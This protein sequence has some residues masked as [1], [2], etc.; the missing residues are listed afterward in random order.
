MSEHSAPPTQRQRRQTWRDRWHIQVPTSWIV[1]VTALGLMLLL[2]LSLFFIQAAGHV[3]DSA[4]SNAAKVTAVQSQAAPLAGQVQSVCDQGGLAATQLNAAGA[5][6]QASKVQSVIEIPGPTGPQGPGPSQAEI[7]AS[8]NA[9]FAA[10]PLPA[11]QL[12]PVSE[13]AG[14]VASYI[15]ANPPAAGVPGQNA[16]AAM[17]SD[18]V[19]NYCAANNGC[20]GPQGATGAAGPSG[21]QGEQGQQGVAGPQGEAGPTGPQ[22]PPPATYT[23]QVPNALGGSTTETCTESAPGSTTYACA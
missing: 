22:G 10:H 6:T 9:Y 21:A 13:V 4:D 17:V 11:G 1:A 23:I 2:V 3:Q 15:A 18:A 19:T 12:P 5:C 8:V 7:D 16:T 14:L 20:A